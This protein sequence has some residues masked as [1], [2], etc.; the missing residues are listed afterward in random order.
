MGKA[1]GGSSILNF[2]LYVRGNKYD[3][4]NWAAL[5]NDG[6]SYNDVL[7]FFKKSEKNMGHFI[8]G[9]ASLLLET[10]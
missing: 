8:E 9:M 6:W 3:Y 5:G 2:L 7:P 10:E 1:L 4:D